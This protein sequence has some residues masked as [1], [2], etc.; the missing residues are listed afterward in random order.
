[1]DKKSF[2]LVASDPVFGCGFSAATTAPG[3]VTLRADRPA[4]MASAPT[5]PTRLLSATSGLPR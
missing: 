4:P 1:M 3:P 5:T 2:A